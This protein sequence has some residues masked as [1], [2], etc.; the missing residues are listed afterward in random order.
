MITRTLV[1]PTILGLA[2]MA[3]GG[4]SETTEPLVWHRPPVDSVTYPTVNVTPQA[5]TVAR[6][7]RLSLFL[8]LN[9]FADDG[10]DHSPIWSSS[11]SNV[12]QVSR[13]IVNNA[14]SSSIPS[15]IAYAAGVGSA[16]ITVW[17]AGRSAS[18][19]VT[20]TETATN[21]P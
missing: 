5:A 6:G 12:V 16:T 18:I 21:N 13:L 10:S 19:P 3:C 20:V 11:N 7:T 14:P 15:A 2:L 4:G 8:A 17:V 9:G 1:L